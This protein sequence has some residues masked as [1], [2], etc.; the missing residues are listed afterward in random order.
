L[1]ELTVEPTAWPSALRAV[2]MVTPVANCPSASRNSRCE[3]GKAERKT[4]VGKAEFTKYRAQVSDHNGAPRFKI[5]RS[6]EHLQDLINYQLEP[7]RS[8]SVRA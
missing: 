8:Q 1:K 7:C 4:E 6:K 3:K 2:M 5:S